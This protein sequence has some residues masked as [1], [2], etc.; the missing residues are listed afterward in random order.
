[1]TQ[2]GEPKCLGLI[3]FTTYIHQDPSLFLALVGH[4]QW[5]IQGF[6]C[7]AQPLH[8]HLSGAGTSK[9]NDHVTLTEDVQGAFKTFKKACLKTHTLDFADFNMPFFLQTDTSKLGL[10]AVYHRNRLMVST[11]L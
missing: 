5:F 9:N 6:T 7:I 1:M 4:Y 11:I 10:G 3:C 2:Q 8:E